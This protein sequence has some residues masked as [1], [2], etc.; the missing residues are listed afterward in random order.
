MENQVVVIEI[1]NTND[2]DGVNVL[3]LAFQTFTSRGNKNVCS[4]L[5]FF[6]KRA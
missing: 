6:F 5:Y 2:D 1:C 4:E 3:F